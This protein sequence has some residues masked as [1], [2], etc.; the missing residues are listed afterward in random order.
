MKISQFSQKTGLSPYTLRYYERKGLLRV[1]RDQHNQR[2]YQEADCA[3]VRF[4]QRLKDTGML[5]R[6]IKTYA[7]LRYQ[8][9]STMAER[10]A[11]LEVHRSFVQKEQAKWADYLSNLDDK[12]SIYQ[13]ELR[14]QG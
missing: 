9:D 14:K 2:D 7:D 6:D 1:A 5:L 11:M 4:I 12:T 13:L 8:G 3:W 10:L